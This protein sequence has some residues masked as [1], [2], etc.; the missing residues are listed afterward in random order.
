[1]PNMQS[2]EEISVFN[3]QMCGQ[4][5]EGKGGIVVSPTDLTRLCSFLDISSD[6]F[7]QRFCEYLG[8]K[9]QICIGEDGNCIFFKK[10]LGCA[11]HEGKPDICRAWPFF[12][13][14]LQDAESFTMAKDFCPGIDKNVSHAAFCSAGK[15]YLTTHKLLASDS[16]CEAN[17]LIVE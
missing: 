10:G 7:I 4:C 2:T 6:A 8:G 5:C 9:L 14:N 15:K 12:R 13:G 17:A 1:M 16:S 3:C 11:V